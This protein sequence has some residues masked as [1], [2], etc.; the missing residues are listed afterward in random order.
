MIIDDIKA[1]IYDLPQ[2]DFQALSGWLIGTERKRREAAPEVAAG[3]AEVVRG[4]RQSGSVATP[5][6]PVDPEDPD[7]YPAWQDPG[8]DHSKMYLVGDRVRHD[9]RIWESGVDMLNSWEPGSAHT[10]WVDITDTLT[11]DEPEDTPEPDGP[12]EPD[13]PDP[14]P[15]IPEWRS[16]LS[17]KAGDL[18]T[19]NGQT[20]RVKIDHQSHAGWVP[21]PATHAVFEQV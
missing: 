21:G 13:G 20:W 15:E 3:Q 10:V 18:V 7:T 19:H 4:M 12:E 16:G 11:Q 9:G 1:A 2:A 17:L 8:T 14:T 6:E 5:P